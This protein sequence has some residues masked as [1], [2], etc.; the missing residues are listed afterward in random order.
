MSYLGS[1]NSNQTQAGGS[2][3]KVRKLANRKKIILTFQTICFSKFRISKKKVGSSSFYFKHGL[4]LVF[5][6]NLANL[7]KIDSLGNEVE[8]KVEV[9]HVFLVLFYFAFQ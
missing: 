4:S 5:F 1:N 3:K 9:I 6:L 7:E 8:V 2:L